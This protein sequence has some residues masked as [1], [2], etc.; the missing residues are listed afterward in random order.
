MTETTHDDEKP[1]PRRVDPVDEG[2][3]SPDPDD[4]L[5]SE[6]YYADAIS[7]DGTLGVYAR[8]GDTPNLGVALMSFAIVTAPHSKRVS[9]ALSATAPLPS[10]VRLRVCSRPPLKVV[11]PV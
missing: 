4:R 3:H 2:A 8:L 9:Q 10:E 11:P 1:A 6:S 7:D 5:W